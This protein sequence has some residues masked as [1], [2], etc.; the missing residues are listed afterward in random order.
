MPNAETSCS[1]RPAENPPGVDIS[2]RMELDRYNMHDNA[3]HMHIYKYQDSNGCVTEKAHFRSGRHRLFREARAMKYYYVTFRSVTFAQRGE[4]MLQKAGIRCTLQRTPKW[5][6]AQG[7][8][9]SLRL[10]TQDVKPALQL[11]QQAQIPMRKVYIQA[12]DG[13]LEE[14]M[15]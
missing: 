15:P 13:Q 1:Q 12:R 8:G 7:C 14:W 9:Y 4:K 5:I 10:W 6:E 11:L 2:E 3:P